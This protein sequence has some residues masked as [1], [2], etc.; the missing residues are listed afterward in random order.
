MSGYFDT[1]IF[2]QGVARENRQM[3]QDGDTIT[4]DVG[5][6]EEPTWLYAEGGGA[7]VRTA[8][9]NELKRWYVSFKV[10]RICRFFDR[11]GKPIERPRNA[12][13]DG[14]RW[15]CVL[16]YKVLNGDAA[17]LQPRGFWADA[18]QLKPADEITFAPMEANATPTTVNE[19]VASE[20]EQPFPMAGENDKDLP[21]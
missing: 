19:P 8:E 5:F 12:D 10:G 4:L 11:N 18:I 15:D 14:K 20:S 3:K 1:K 21:F 6:A 13:L 16:Q 17:K 9:V 2:R 7:Y